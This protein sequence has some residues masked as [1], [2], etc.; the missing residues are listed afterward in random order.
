M[1]W[2]VWWVRLVAAWWALWRAF[3][4]AT[5]R[6][7]YRGQLPEGGKMLGPTF[8]ADEIRDYMDRHRHALRRHR[9]GVWPGNWR[10]RGGPD[11]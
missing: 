5:G 9:G 7:V 3:R 10:H 2:R 4:R 11:K 6:R 1:T 8:T